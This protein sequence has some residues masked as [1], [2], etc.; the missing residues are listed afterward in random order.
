MLE[1]V[2]V[3]RRFG[4]RWALRGVDLAVSRGRPLALLGANGSGKTTLLKTFAGLLRPTGGEVR[5]D[6]KPLASHARGRIGLLGHEPLLYPSLTVRE[7]L[8]FY[9][10]LFGLPRGRIDSRLSGL[11]ETLGLA[12]R[13]DEP[14]RALS[15]GFRQRAALARALLHE[16]EVILLDEPFAGLDLEAAERLEAMVGALCAA[17]GGAKPGRIVL[18]AT[19]DP[20]R[21]R[22]IAKEAAVL[23][24]GRVAFRGA[25]EALSR[26]FLGAPRAGSAAGGPPPAAGGGEEGR[27]G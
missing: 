15:Q 1:A 14:V 12:G 25:S 23:A 5:L 26:A 18:F 3:T 20:A 4:W 9:G 13:L 24:E 27:C 7:N 2:G 10:R 11:A 19:H 16:P 22:A 17:D 6:G 21:A 8:R